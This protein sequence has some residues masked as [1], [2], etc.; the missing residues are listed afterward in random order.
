[1]DNLI[2]QLKNDLKG[3][4]FDLYIYDVLKK[5]DNNSSYNNSSNNNS[6]DNNSSDDN[7]SDDNKIEVAS[8]HSD[9]I[10]NNQTEMFNM[11]FDEIYDMNQI[12]TMIKEKTF[13]RDNDFIDNYKNCIPIA[14]IKLK[15]NIKIPMMKENNDIIHII[16][17]ESNNLIHI[18]V[19]FSHPYLWYSYDVESNEIITILNKIISMYNPIE[20]PPIY[21]KESNGFIGSYKMLDMTEN[22]LME[23][24]VIGE[25]NELFTW[26][27]LWDEHPFRETLLNELLSEF[28]YSKINIYSMQQINDYITINVKTQLSKSL[29]KFV[30]YDGLFF[31]Y[32][33]YN[34][35]INSNIDKLNKLILI[36]QMIYLLT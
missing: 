10:N 13:Y 33:K 22:D 25:W 17:D 28:Q 1:M 12:L 7:S 6:S 29:I 21:E 11:I 36:I 35:L 4:N 32:I 2:N 19:S 16:Y 24:L 8:E 5:S 20:Y 18:C 15:K 34:P 31:V 3:I 9:T 26:G 14:L 30:M 27:A 23:N